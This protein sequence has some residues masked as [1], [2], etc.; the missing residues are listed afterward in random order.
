V[1][2][3]ALLVVLSLAAAGCDT[4]GRALERRPAERVT[5]D[6]RRPADGASRLD[7]TASGAFD[8]TRAWSHLE[9]LVALGPRPAGSAEL[10]RAR[11]Y[12]T[13]QLAASGLTVQEQPFTAETPAGR[14]DMVNL[15]VR[16]P[17]RRADRLLV[18]GHYDTKLMRG[19]RFVG[20]NDGGS[21]AAWLIELARALAAA[22]VPREHT[23]ELVWFD[24]EEAFCENWSD[25]GR[26]DS[27]DNTYGSRY[28]V[29]AARAGDAL[30]SIKAMILVDMIADRDLDI[31]RDPNSTPALTDTIWRVARRLGHEAAF[32]DA[33]LAVE[34]DHIPFLRAGVPSVDIIDLNYP[35]WHT[36]ADTLDKLSA[37]SLQ[38][39]GDVVMAALAELDRSRP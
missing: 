34:D 21:S 10:R 38:V 29:Q 20:A 2:V 12:I 22:T 33:S 17:G 1:G 6:E 8:S 23:I 37:R 19:R 31:R 7:Q 3:P 32:V 15:V 24:G 39:V 26:P 9:Q 13:R 18:T 25:C 30:S 4:R 28:Y 27:P 16:L 35:H 14:V 5:A 36:P 11:A